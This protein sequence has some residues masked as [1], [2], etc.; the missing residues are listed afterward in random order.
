M[1]GAS[2]ILNYVYFSVTQLKWALDFLL[3]RSSSHLIYNINSTTISENSSSHGFILIRSFEAEST[4]KSGA[5]ILGTW[6]SVEC[7]VCLCEIEEGEAVRELICNHSFHKVCLDRWLGFGRMTCPLCRN[8]INKSSFL[9]VDINEQVILFDF[10][11]GRS[12]DRC[13]WW[14]R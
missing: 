2:K 6:D 9:F 14:L 7:A 11:C 13:Q 10:R 12:R 1:F 4:G 8:K 3:L 5:T